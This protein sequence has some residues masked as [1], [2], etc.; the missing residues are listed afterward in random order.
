MDVIID[1]LII[2]EDRPVHI[3]KHGVKPSETREVTEGD[4][5][6]IEG[7]QGRWLLIGKT[8]KGRFLTVIV[9]PREKRGVYGLVT[10]RP[11]SKEEKSFYQEFILQ[12]GGEQDGKNNKS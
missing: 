12:Q 2:E 3:A 10:A 9:G 7:R 5:T 6:Y 11:A 1:E 4:Y 8:K